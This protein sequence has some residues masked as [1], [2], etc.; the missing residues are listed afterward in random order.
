MS[1]AVLLFPS[2]RFC[3]QLMQNREAD[4][5]QEHVDSGLSFSR[6]RSFA[7]S[8]ALARAGMLTLTRS[9][10]LI[11]RS[12]WPRELHALSSF[13]FHLSHAMARIVFHLRYRSHVLDA[14]LS[15]GLGHCVFRRYTGHPSIIKMHTSLSRSFHR[16]SAPWCARAHVNTHARTPARPHART[17]T[18]THTYTH[19]Q[20]HKHT[21]AHTYTHTHSHTQANITQECVHIQAEKYH[22]TVAKAENGD[23]WEYE[24]WNPDRC[25]PEVL[26]ACREEQR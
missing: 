5:W 15:Q 8:L 4:N 14:F 9:I 25:I 16:P 12:I 26:R 19:T 10:A 17:H 1:G 20:A 7:R 2:R 22:H 3:Q 21:H 23:G 18:H 13:S 24:F 6:A 11:I